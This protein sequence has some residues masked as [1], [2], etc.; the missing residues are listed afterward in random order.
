[1]NLSFVNKGITN[2]INFLAES[3]LASLF[4]VKLSG[5]NPDHVSAQIAP[6][7]RFGDFPME[8][9]RIR[10]PAMYAGSFPLYFVGSLPATPST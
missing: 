5:M 7:K 9:P 8:N 6:T 3:S 10:L 4:W 1:M 2:Q